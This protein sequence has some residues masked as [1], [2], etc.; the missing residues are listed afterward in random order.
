MPPNRPLQPYPATSLPP[1]TPPKKRGPWLVLSLILF[2]LLFLGAAVFAVWAY[3]GRQDYKNNVA[4]KVNQAVATAIQVE[5]TKAADKYAELEKSPTKTYQ[6]QAAYGSL[7]ITYPKTWSAYV[8]EIDQSAN[9][10]DGFFHPGFVPAT[11]TNTAYALR[12]QVVNQRYSQVIGQFDGLVKA[13]KVK[14]SPYTAPNLK[15]VLGSRIEG[16]ITQGQKD[17]MVLLPLRDKT[18]KIWTESQQYVNDL[19][20]IVLANLTFEQ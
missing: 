8:I 1:V 9:P 16:E 20:T 13:N 6:A 10:V 11:Q 2:I 14:L 12:V 7:K 4:G 17:T 18:L 15:T 19:D 3:Q 5:D